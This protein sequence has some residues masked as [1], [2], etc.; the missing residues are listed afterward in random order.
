MPSLEPTLTPDAITANVTLRWKR[1]LGFDEEPHS[2]DFFELGGTSLKA[3]QLLSEIENDLG[4]SVP[5]MVFALQPTLQGL[6]SALN[7]S[8]RSDS[9]SL[10][11][12]QLLGDRLP[13]FFIHAE[14]GHVLF[15][16]KMAV[17][18]G[19]DQPMY[20]LQSRGLDGRSEP[21][22][23][24]QEMAAYY[25]SAMKSIQPEGPY[26]LGGYC[27]GALLALEMTNQ[28]Q[29][30]GEEVSHLAVFS[31]D[32]SWMNVA[33]FNTQLDYHLREMGNT[34]I[35]GVSRYIWWR[36]LFRLHRGY[37]R[38]VRILHRVYA[39]RGK[40]LPARLRY[41]YIADLNYR[42]GWDFQPQPF[43]GTISY[44]QG[45]ADRRRDPRPF[46]GNLATGGI[47]THAVTGEMA[48]IFDSPH[49]DTLAAKLSESLTRPA[50]A[51]GRIQ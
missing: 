50:E 10:V 46:W 11:P 37:S 16:Q 5:L 14:F 2:D 29:G 25:V 9:T 19:P 41:V 39:W 18:L 42:S 49:V 28:L 30:A 38:A 20:G 34:G 17:A 43:R 22:T 48:A 36:I 15:A 6:L 4:L 47:E 51:N 26:R 33:G 40:A 21:L 12:M 27:M 8:A 7:G 13:F 45:E 31:T 1:V 3:L 35:G 44:F 32:A 24:M 23:T